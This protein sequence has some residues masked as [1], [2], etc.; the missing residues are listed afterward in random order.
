MSEKLLSS[1]NNKQREAVTAPPVSQL[2]LAGAGSGKTRV[3]T[4]RI[5]WLLAQSQTRPENILAVTFTNKAAKE[6]MTRLE[7]ILPYDLR[8]MWVGTFHGLCNRI[9]RRHAEAAGLPKTFQIIDSSDQL[10]IIKRILKECNVDTDKV[11]PRSVQNYIN[12][13]K[14]HGIRANRAAMMKDVEPLAVELYRRYEAQ[15]LK[16]GTVDFAELLLRCYELLDRN[17]MIRTQY[18]HRFH[19][20][21]VDEFQDTNILQYRWLQM[22][23]GCG[24][25]PNNESKNA[26]FAVGDDDQS[27][28][29]FRGAN[30][31]NM[32]DFLKDFHVPAPVRL[33]EN[34]R[35]TGA[36]LEA[37][38]EL[39]RHNAKRLGKN[40]WTSGGKGELVQLVE[41]KDENDEAQWV[42][43]TIREG[44]HAGQQY[45]QYAILYRMNA[46]SRALESALARRGIPYR[47]YGGLRFFERLEI[48]HVLA[49]LRVLQGNVDDTNFL[50]VVNMPTRGIGAKTIDQLLDDASHAGLSLWQT[51]THPNYEPGPKLRVFKD[52]TYAMRSEA[53]GK[54]LTE[55]VKLVIKMSGLQA[56]Y[57]KDR[58]GTE[59]LENL[60]E[61][62]TAASG[63]MKSEGIEETA[64]AFSV[65]PELDQTPLEGFL[66]QATL[67]AG[68]KNEGDDQDAVQ[69]MTVHASKGLEFKNVII[70]GVE[71]GIFPHFSAL[72]EKG[73]D[74]LSEERRLMY[75]AITRAQKHLVMTHC[76]ERMLHGETRDCLLSPFVSEIP[77]SLFERI[78]LP[79]DEE[80]YGDDHDGYD[81]RYGWQ[82]P[83]FGGS[84]YEG[85]HSERSHY[86]RSSGG[87]RWDKDD[88]WRRD[89][90]G[91]GK[92][93]RSSED[94]MV[95]RA[96]AAAVNSNYGFKV[97][98]TVVH[99]KLGEGV[100]TSIVG[101]GDDGRIV[102]NFA[103]AG[104]K[105]LL[106]AIAQKHLAKLN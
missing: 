21:L 84:K 2:I 79:K 90:A 87:A 49:Y 85:G 35:S 50:R 100:V 51:L 36:I 91:S 99:S 47:I 105:E 60:A 48:K 46:Q 88:D 9:L 71:E 69:L 23:A 66:T 97:G 81:R 25:G 92:V 75:V 31:G 59:R 52:L 15:C 93:Y 96:Q 106:L 45:R 89:L 104:Q 68:E 98:D 86:S 65:V 74:G 26:V 16:D 94:P 34:Y 77:E 61:L 28:Y 95:R 42:V 4:T 32:S 30:V 70:V 58:E 18:Q 43:D 54:P 8:N 22:L 17:E 37:A 33:E 3:L 56:M 29:A 62:V 102:I 10:S 63:Y 12:W 101:H 24:M 76:R 6:M 19:H 41:R 14:E 39:I 1:L 20:I 82:K 53:A 13:N 40:L 44:V 57:E 78:D 73:D 64:D 55:V 5:A 80:T 7:A 103:R 27:I 38:N 67:E 83:S 72:K 11:E